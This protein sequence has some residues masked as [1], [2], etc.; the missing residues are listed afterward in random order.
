MKFGGFFYAFSRIRGARMAARST[1]A[2]PA[3]VFPTSIGIV[4]SGSTLAVKAR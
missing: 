4:I 2:I 1:A 3:T